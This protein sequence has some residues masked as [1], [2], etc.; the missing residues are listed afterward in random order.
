MFSTLS[1]GGFI[2]D[3]TIITPEHPVR[4]IILGPGMILAA[5]PFAFHYHIFS[6]S[7]LWKKKTIS[8]EVKVYL[9]AMAAAIPVFYMLC[10]GQ[11]DIYSVLFHIVSGSTTT[12]FQYLDIS[13]I[14]VGAKAF[15][16]VAMLVGG[17]A[18]ST[19]GGIKIGRLVILYQEFTKKAQEKDM[20]TITGQSTS[21][22]ISAMANPSGILNFFQCCARNTRSTILRRWSSSRSAS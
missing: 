20:A 17:T 19:A 11:V 6:R 21:T 13:S 9:I 3:S 10:G 4:L 1:S 8:A 18:F 16:I 7:G 22:S 5:L 12:G 2:P 14:P 15:M